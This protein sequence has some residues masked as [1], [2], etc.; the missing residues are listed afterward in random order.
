MEAAP[1][2]C[3]APPTPCVRAA[4]CDVCDVGTVLQAPAGPA[5]AP[6]PQPPALRACGSATPG[7]EAG[8]T[9]WGLEGG[10]EMER[11]AQ[12]CPEDPGPSRLVMD[13]GVRGGLGRS[14]GDR[15]ASQRAHSQVAVS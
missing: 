3:H 4:R 6:E 1:A 11:A 15:G 8:E 5:S 10:S 12:R 7:R 2:S 9:H 14:P 13:R